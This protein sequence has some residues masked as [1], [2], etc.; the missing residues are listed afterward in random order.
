MVT[1]IR[2]PRGRLAIAGIVILLVLVVALPVIAVQVGAHCGGNGLF[3]S[4]ATSDWWAQHAKS[5]MGSETLIWDVAPARRST[6]VNWGFLSGMQY[7]N[8]TG[9]NL[10]ASA[11][12]IP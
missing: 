4:N 10:S 12:C 11:Q 6:T 3:R 1:H 9:P 8:V 7:A 2:S 5:G